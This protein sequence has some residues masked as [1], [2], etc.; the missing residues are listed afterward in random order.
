MTERKKLAWLFV[1]K[2]VEVL[3][4]GPVL[5]VQAHR[6]VAADIATAAPNSPEEQHLGHSRRGAM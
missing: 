2:S 4:G 1:V 6:E 3:I 5:G